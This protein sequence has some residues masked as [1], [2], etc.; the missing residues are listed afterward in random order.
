MISPS[1]SLVTSF[2]MEP[3]Q[4]AGWINSKK[5]IVWLLKPL[6]INLVCCFWHSPAFQPIS[7]LSWHIHKTATQCGNI[8]WISRVHNDK[9]CWWSIKIILS[10]GLNHSYNASKSLINIWWDC[11]I[12]EKIMYYIIDTTLNHC[13][14][15][16]MSGL[17][18]LSKA[19]N[20]DLTWEQN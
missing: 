4:V 18:Y 10:H 2:Y 3:R 1:L 16:R 13:K 15:L 6:P 8:L 9:H 14:K 20:G 5:S 11:L 12:V 19:S 17:W 7:L